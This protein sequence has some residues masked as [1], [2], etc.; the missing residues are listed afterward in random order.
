MESSVSR[1]YFDICPRRWKSSD[2]R[3]YFDSTRSISRLGFPIIM[4]NPFG[5]TYIYLSRIPGD[6]WEEY[7]GIKPLM[8]YLRQNEWEE[9]SDA[10]RTTVPLWK[11]EEYMVSRCVIVYAK[12]TGR[13]PEYNIN[14]HKIA[15]ISFK[16]PSIGLKIAEME[17]PD[18][19]EYSEN[20]AT[21]I[22]GLIRIPRWNQANLQLS[23]WTSNN[24]RRQRLQI[25]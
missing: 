7:Q 6:V 16:K 18:L 3:T 15:H 4:C 17:S 23:I 10:S 13:I 8:D 25:A 24:K 14:I 12:R 21:S 19:H 9:A 22:I 1:T 2:W 11:D 5:Y 20:I